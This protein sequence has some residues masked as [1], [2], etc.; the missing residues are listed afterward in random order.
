MCKLRVRSYDSVKYPALLMKAKH[1]TDFPVIVVAFIINNLTSLS[2]SIDHHYTKCYHHIILYSSYIL[3][4]YYH[5]HTTILLLIILPSKTHVSRKY[6]SEYPRLRPYNT[7]YFFFRPGENEKE[8]ERNLVRQPVSGIWSRL[9]S[10]FFHS[11]VHFPDFRDPRLGWGDR[12]GEQQKKKTFQGQMH[13]RS[14]MVFGL[15]PSL[16]SFF[17]SGEG[18]TEREK[19]KSQGSIVWFKIVVL[20]VALGTLPPSLPHQPA[21]SSLLLSTLWEIPHSA[22]IETFY[23]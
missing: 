14:H 8:C 18:G 1:S 20:T 15:I 23:I 3:L 13:T 16:N 4:L 9:T 10:L 17:K 19:G 7:W 5:T 22:I 6:N 12:Q 2:I 21:P 11:L